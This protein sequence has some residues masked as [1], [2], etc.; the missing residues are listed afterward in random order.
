MSP[1]RLR[2]REAREALGLTVTALADLAGV[3]R[4]TVSDLEHGKT[5]GVD[6]DTLE[7]LAEVL[8]VHPSWLVVQD[9]E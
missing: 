8:G 1:V 9:D 3:R 5:R 2:V 4:A 7:R 6:F